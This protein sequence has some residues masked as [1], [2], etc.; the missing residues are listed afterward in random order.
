MCGIFAYCGEQCHAG[1]LVLKGLKQL[2]YRGYDSWGVTWLPS[3]TDELLVEKRV[4]KIGTSHIVDSQPAGLALG[5]TRWATHGGVT[6]ANAH[7]HLNQTKTLALVH[8]GIVEN[9]LSLK[10]KLQQHGYVFSS[11][12]D[13]EVVLHLL[14]KNLQQHDFLHAA[15]KTFQACTG[16]NAFVVVYVPTQEMIA[17]SNGSPLVFGKT[18][19]SYLVAS[20]AV[21]LS[22]YCQQ[23]YFLE[24]NDFLHIRQQKTKLYSLPNLHPKKV[25]MKKLEFV[26][27][28]TD[29]GNY[30]SFLAKEI[31]EQPLIIDSIT[32]RLVSQIKRYARHDLNQGFLVGCGTAY[33]A[34][35][36]GSYFFAKLCNQYVAAVTGSEFYAWRDAIDELKHVTFLSQSGETIEITEH[37]S[38]VKSKKVSYGAIVNRS[39][40]T[41][42]RLSPAKIKLGVGPEQSVLATKSYTAMVTTLFLLAHERAGT[43]VHASSLLHIASKA[44]KKIIS[45]LFV[46]KHVV[47]LA[48]ILAKKKHIFIIGRGAAYPLALEAALKLKEST[49]IHAEGFAAGELKHGAIA[50]IES[51]TPC[52]VFVLDDE[53]KQAVLSSAMEV[54]AR[55]ALVIGIACE[56]NQVFDYF[57][58]VSN[59]GVLTV[60][61][62]IMSVQLLA[63]HITQ[64][65]GNDPDK[66]RNLA[67]SVTVR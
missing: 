11:E 24:A 66:P 39:G 21:A 54:K 22:E 40:S 7:P 5:H 62:A 10:N 16:L 57:I 15:Q 50:L 33:H 42:E 44:A 26:F 45:P 12:T 3:A 19:S 47:P 4:G 28:D 13:T 35:L 49:Y 43:T 41:L 29:I 6:V 36:L 2:E 17:F 34:A 61:P 27:Q 52:V 30:P 1:S 25:V 55:G 59:V 58:P 18:K 32:D 56:N 23:V 51:G 65:L 64:L 8:N 48:K 60:L 9:Y 37:L 46:K 63:L 20:D 38:Y 31:A 67:K 14:E 53:H